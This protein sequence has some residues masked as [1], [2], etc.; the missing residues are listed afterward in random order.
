MDALKHLILH[1][2][3]LYPHKQAQASETL[4]LHDA[5]DGSGSLAA[6]TPAPV[7][8]EGAAW[9]VEFGTF[10]LQAGGV[11]L[12]PGGDFVTT[13]ARIGL[14]TPDVRVVAVVSGAT[15]V[16]IGYY[17]IGVHLRC[18]DY[19]NT[20]IVSY[21]SAE[22][23]I[24]RISE[25]TLEILA[26]LAVAVD[27]N[28]DHIINV[29]SQGGA[30]TATLDGEHQVTATATDLVSTGVGIHL[31]SDATLDTVKDFKVYALP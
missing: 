15:S 9:V 2:P 21:D 26:S 19:Q 3:V 25:G 24:A 23:G 4:I 28:A 1:Q 18:A 29:V 31:G 10:F 22:F 13:C 14:D 6:H 20:Y 27:M 30:I 16:G 12:D 7:A 11:V 17:G 5:F 8:P